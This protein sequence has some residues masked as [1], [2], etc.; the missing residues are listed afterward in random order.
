MKKDIFVSLG[1]LLAF[2]FYMIPF[3]SPVSAKVDK[4]A[5]CHATGS[6]SNPWEFLELPENALDG[7]DDE[8]EHPN[9][10]IGVEDVNEDGKIDKLDCGE[11]GEEDEC[12]IVAPTLVSPANLATG[13]GLNV[14]FDWSDVVDAESYRIQVSTNSNFSSFVIDSPTA[15]SAYQATLAANTQ[16]FW[17]VYA[18][19]TD[20]D[21]CE[22]VSVVA[23]FTTEGDGIGGGGTIVVPSVGVTSD[24][25]GG[26]TVTVPDG[27]GGGV[28]PNTGSG[29]LVFTSLLSTLGA[30][31]ARK[32]LVK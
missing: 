10:I 13:V 21:E 20:V 15:T 31:L 19:D 23:S 17:R 30:W 32:K 3:A 7:H 18:I 2:V 11:N 1:I 4:V 8:E 22:E 27:I 28:L 6:E 29:A 25:I 5:I 26:G 24:G 16:Y 14:N 9:D 12:E